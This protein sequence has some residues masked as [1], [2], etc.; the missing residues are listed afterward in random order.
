MK[1]TPS[2]FRPGCCA[3]SSSLEKYATSNDF[4]DDTLNF[5]KTHPLMDEA[6]PSVINRPW[7]LR[8]MVRW[9]PST[10][11]PTGLFPT[12]SH[13]HISGSCFE[14][15][16]ASSVIT[17][18]GSTMKC[19]RVGW[20]PTKPCNHI[21]SEKS[22]GILG[23][24]LHMTA[25]RGNKSISFPGSPLVQSLQKWRSSEG[26]SVDDV[27]RCLVGYGCRTSCRFHPSIVPWLLTF[28]VE[29]EQKE[30]LHK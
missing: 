25:I 14:V 13:A 29:R 15:A 26:E 5:I 12:S 17:C 22:L 1:Q 24:T 19:W 21:P 16:Q 7:F 30:G 18:I 8:T 9:V 3:G 2:L 20:M 11:S 10:P 23:L 28:K 6:V 27:D 4:P